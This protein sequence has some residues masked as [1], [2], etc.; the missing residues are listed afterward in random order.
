MKS[1][2]TNWFV[3]VLLII[4]AL[5]ILFPLYMAISIALKTPQELAK[6]VLSFPTGMHF[7][8]F[9]QAMAVTHFWHAFRNSAVITVS[10]VILTLITNSMVAYAIA[11]N[12]HRK[13]F[14]FLY[15]YFLSAMF[16]PFPIIMLPIVKEMSSL[17]LLNTIGLIILY[18]VYGLSFNTFVYVGYIKSIPRELEEAAMIDGCSRWWVFWRIVFPLL[19]PINATIGIITS[20]WA[21]NDFLLPLIILSD[22]SAN[23]LPLVQ[24]AFQSQFNTNFNLAFASYLLALIPMIILYV[25]SQKWVIG[26]VTRG[27]IK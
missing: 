5:F 7:E 17:G 12:M 9:T 3:T 4:G 10:V 11:R 23:T 16:I 25:F 14:K 8:N 24:Y 6:S 20:L 18:V 22:P 27:A 13:F 15:Y 1:N 26:G 2:K 19:K 21:W